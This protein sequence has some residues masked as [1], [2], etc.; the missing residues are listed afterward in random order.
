MTGVTFQVKETDS[1]RKAIYVWSP[2][3]PLLYLLFEPQI[4]CNNYFLVN[5]FVTQ[6]PIRRMEMMVQFPVKVD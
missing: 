4:Q 3:G 1:S 2:G 6:V 5:M